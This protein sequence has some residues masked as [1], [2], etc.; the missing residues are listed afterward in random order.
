MGQKFAAYDSTGSIIGFYDS[1]DS[2]AP[3]GAQVIDITDAQWKTC[4]SNQGWTVINGALV[5]PVQP[6]AAQIAA[7]QA[8]TAWSSY[9]VSAKAALDASD[10]TVLRCYENT[11]TT[12]AA[13]STYRKALRSIVS[14]AS[15]DPTQ[16]LPVRPAYPTGT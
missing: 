2:P 3:Q 1:I 6:T 14:A 5:A 12:P 16:P 10:I 15:G 9:Q 8:A 4:I 7:Q 11:V 13:W